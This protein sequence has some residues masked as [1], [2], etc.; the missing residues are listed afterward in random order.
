MINHSTPPLARLGRN[1]LSD[2]LR[3]RLR[4]AFNGA[5]QRITAQRAKSNPSRFDLLSRQER[6]TFVIDHYQATVALDHRSL[7]GKIKRHD[8]Y[9]L[10]H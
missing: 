4:A 8:G 10:D 6:H 3:Q 5:G 9:V 2:D 1:R 7:F